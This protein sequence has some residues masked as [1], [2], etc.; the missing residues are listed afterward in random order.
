MNI[1]HTM[2]TK[3][4]TVW[5]MGNMCN[6]VLISNSILEVKVVFNNLALASK[7]PLW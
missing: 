6:K 7:V 2:L 3:I 1:T 5:K 4:M